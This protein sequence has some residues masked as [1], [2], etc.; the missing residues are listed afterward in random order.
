MVVAG[1]SRKLWCAAV[2]AIFE[3][4]WNICQLR[5]LSTKKNFEGIA[6]KLSCILCVRVLF[7]FSHFLGM[8][9]V[10]FAFAFS[11]GLD[12]SRNLATLS[13]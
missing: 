10:C 4:L 3:T 6:A 1:V 7:F 9:V 12:S 5:Y 13:N 8:E 2:L 11:E